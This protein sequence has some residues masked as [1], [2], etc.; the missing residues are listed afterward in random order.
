MK[1][2]LFISLFSLVTTVSAATGSV[3]W[4]GGAYRGFNSTTKHFEL[5]PQCFP[6]TTLVK[7]LLGDIADI[8][9]NQ[10]DC[11]EKRLIDFGF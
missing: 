8:Y 11:R 6:Y 1:T 3:T 9:K 5:V 2:L 7:F 10:Q 4:G